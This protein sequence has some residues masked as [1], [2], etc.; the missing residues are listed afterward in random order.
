VTGQP[1]IFQSPEKAYKV[2]GERVT[3]VTGGLGTAIDPLPGLFDCALEH[4]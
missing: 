4:L 2:T 1:V 3:P